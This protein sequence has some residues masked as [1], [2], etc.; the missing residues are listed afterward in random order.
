M[1]G[2]TGFY[3]VG[4]DGLK[5]LTS[6]DLL[7]LASQSAGITDVSHHIPSHVHF[8]RY[9]VE[10]KGHEDTRVLLCRSGWS[11]VAL[12][13][14]TATSASW[15]K[16]ILLPQPPKQLGLQRWDF[17]KLA[18][19]VLNSCPQSKVSLYRLGWRAGVHWCDL[20]LLQPQL[21]PPQIAGTT[22]TTVEVFRYVVQ[23][24]I[25]LLTSE[26]GFHHVGQA[27]LKPLTSDDPPT[28]ASQSSE[29]AGMS[30]HPRPCV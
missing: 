5:L 15:V 19:L 4:Q 14:L 24:G 10:R 1:P 20:G 23:A 2:E 17:A 22:G 28:F 18:R 11:A 21:P 30:H 29:I 16:V 7:A 27:G 3:H 26:K 13:R 12:S 8:R 6:N 25:R 9:E